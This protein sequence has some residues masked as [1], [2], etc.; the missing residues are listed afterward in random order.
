MSSRR[1]APPTLITA[2]RDEPTSLNRFRY[3]WISLA[4]PMLLSSRTMVVRVS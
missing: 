1:M 2:N 3:C 4:L